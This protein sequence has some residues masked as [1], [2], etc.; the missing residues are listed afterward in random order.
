MT[1]AYVRQKTLTR[2]AYGVAALA[3]PC[4]LQLSVTPIGWALGMPMRLSFTDSLLATLGV[5]VA[6]FVVSRM[7]DV[8]LAS[9]DIGFSAA[10]RVVAAV[11][12]MIVL[13][14]GYLLI[15]DSI[16][17][18]AL[19]A[20]AVCGVFFALSTI[21]DRRRRGLRYGESSRQLSPR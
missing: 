8:I 18:A 4:V 6:W 3:I 20:A 19:M 13:G 2:S 7:I 10:G 12:S 9:S 5:F 1:V 15:I 11:S 16:P 21:I 17:V 14:S